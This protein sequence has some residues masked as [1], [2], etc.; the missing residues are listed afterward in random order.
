MKNGKFSLEKYDDERQK[1]TNA[2][3]KT[4]NKFNGLII[5]IEI[6]ALPLNWLFLLD[7]QAGNET[8]GSK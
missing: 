6:M 4:N 1:R 7:G 8:D 5:I 2:F 3:S